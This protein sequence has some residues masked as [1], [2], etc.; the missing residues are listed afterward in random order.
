MISSNV[1]YNIGEIYAPVLFDLAVER[2]ELETIKEDIDEIDKFMFA[3][4]DFHAILMSPYLSGEQKSALAEH[5][6]SGKVSELTLNFLLVAGRKNRLN[7]LPNIIKKFKRL[8]RHIKGH[9]DVW[10]TISHAIG[11]TEKDEIKASL[12]TALKTE[13][14]TLE[15]NVE[16]SI[17][18][19]TI[20][21]YEGKMI[22][23]SI[24][25]RL[26]QAVNTIISRGRNSGKT[27]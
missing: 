2:G 9:K 17:L 24:R 6:F 18:G 13:N 21:R 23:N 26:H 11:Q 15:F 22:D 16:P 25:T 5:L 19:G 8:Y 14:I 1:L 20:I 3:E 4:G 12:A 27:V 10:M 7:G